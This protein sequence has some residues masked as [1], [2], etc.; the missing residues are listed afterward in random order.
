[1]GEHLFYRFLV[2]RNRVILY[3]RVVALGGGKMSQW[4][5]QQAKDE[6]ARKDAEYRKQMQDWA[7][8]EGLI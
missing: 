1:V 2:L 3:V 7:K 6:W 4:T 5:E 8:K